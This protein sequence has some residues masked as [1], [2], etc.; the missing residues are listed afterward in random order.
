MNN[1]EYFISLSCFLKLCTEEWYDQYSVATAFIA[2]LIVIRLSFICVNLF[3][4]NRTSFTRVFC[5]VHKKTFEYLTHNSEMNLRND[6]SLLI[7][8]ICR[9]I[10]ILFLAIKTSLRLENNC[11]SHARTNLLYLF[12]IYIAKEQC[13]IYQLLLYAKLLSSN[14][15]Q[16][17]NWTC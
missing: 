16:Y 6:H 17:F 5:M 15:N 4:K 12:L 8:R 2:P 13:T 11:Y 10:L 14:N 7:L 3:S 9:N 1:F